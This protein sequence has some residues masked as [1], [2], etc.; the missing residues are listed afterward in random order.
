V[1]QQGEIER[2]QGQISSLQSSP[3]EAETAGIYALDGT[4]RGTG[5][6]RV[7]HGSTARAGS[8][9]SQLGTPY[10]TVGAQVASE[11]REFVGERPPEEEEERQR[12]DIVTIADVGGVL[13]PKGVLTIDPSLTYSH[14]DVNKFVFRGVQILDAFLIGRIEASQADRDFLGGSLAARYGVTNRM[15]VSVQVPGVYRRDSVTNTIDPSDPASV[16]IERSTEGYGLGDVEFG[17]Q[18]QINDG[19]NGWPFLVANVKAKAPTG[20]SPFDVR[21]DSDGIELESPTGSGFWAVQ[22]SLTVIAPTDPLVYYGSVSYLL[23]LEKNVNTAIGGIL[24]GKFDPGDAVGVSF[25]AALGITEDVSASF[26]Y[27][28]FYI[29]KNKQEQTALTGPTAGLLIKTES[30]DLQVGAIS[31]ALNQRLKQGSFN[32]QLGVG[33]TEDAPDI[34]ITLRRPLNFA[35]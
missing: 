33:V 27:E 31:F 17:A 10:Q 9:A 21:R 23:N 14:S 15:E 13:T 25:G 22:P 30:D 3:A 19:K 8:G 6:P 32:V 12:I 34:S 29:F 2:I 7:Q 4:N 18:Y 16:E 35:L 5:V 26:G 20:E 24:I 1:S 28:H 11:N